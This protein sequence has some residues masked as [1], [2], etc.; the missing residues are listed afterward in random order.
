[1][2][3]VTKNLISSVIFSRNYKLKDS[4]KAFKHLN[5]MPVMDLKAYSKAK[6]SD[7]F[8]LGLIK[9]TPSLLYT[10]VRILTLLKRQLKSLVR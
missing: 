10:P 6:I 9:H 3:R 1:M 5:S 7:R 8:M 4:K 2:R